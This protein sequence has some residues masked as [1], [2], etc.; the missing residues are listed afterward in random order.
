MSSTDQ[1]NIEETGSQPM[2][3]TVA[4]ATSTAEVLLNKRFEIN[5][6][7]CI[8]G[9]NDLATLSIERAG[10]QSRHCE[11]VR[12][13]AGTFVRELAD[14]LL[15][16]SK[17]LC[18]AWLNE[19]DRIGIGNLCLQVDQL[20]TVGQQTGHRPKP[21]FDD[22]E[23]E[24]RTLHDSIELLQARVEQLKSS[25]NS[26]A[27]CAES[28]ED[29]SADQICE[30]ANEIFEIEDEISCA[31]VE[32]IQENNESGSAIQSSDN[33]NNNPS[34]DP[35]PECYIPQTSDSD[36]SAEDQHA[37]WL[38]EL[39]EL[40]TTAENDA[41]QTELGKNT[42]HQVD[43]EHANMESSWLQQNTRQGGSMP[44]PSKQDANEVLNKIESV[45]S[46][47]EN[48]GAV[49]NDHVG[50]PAVTD[51][52]NSEMDEQPMNNPSNE[53]E[54]V[55]EVLAR[56]QQAGQLEQSLSFESEENETSGQ[57]ADESNTTSPAG[58]NQ[59]A[60]QDSPSFKSGEGDGDSVQD[61][62]SQLFERLRGGESEPI[63]PATSPAESKKTPDFLQPQP[64]AAANSTPAV[65]D[66]MDV[67][68][69]KDPLK[70]SEYKPSQAA[71][72]KTATLKA[73]RQVANQSIHNAIQKSQ[74]KRKLNNSFLY[75]GGT[76]I[77]FCLC[78]LL[79]VMSQSWFDLCFILGVISAIAC[80]ASGFMFAN[81]YVA[82]KKANSQKKAKTKKR[83]SANA[84]E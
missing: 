17:P 49:E 10:L 40:A 37:K 30:C 48:G 14:Q 20:G 32:S 70:L 23:K 65:E 13:P 47:A 28:S 77:A 58:S 2:V 1:S 39:Y 46:E 76:G 18:E 68:N 41:K 31:A 61:Y 79:F 66:T 71:P 52:C 43:E 22:L 21:S 82:G 54:S 57:T 6:V 7:H 9:S 64:A 4:E 27:T 67:L 59:P 12:N 29:P 63:E 26:S 24:N 60:S 25:T 44:I 75:L 33:A 51:Q 35:R 55:A 45:F 56:M 19:G 69:P 83:Q 3:L 38:D 16:N 34:I 84:D 50:Q 81:M 36:P 78:V 73:L 8:L 15:V 80:A 72:E 74:N 11:I 62:M 5:D 42:D 53:N